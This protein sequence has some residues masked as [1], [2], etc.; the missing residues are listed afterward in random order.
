[1]YSTFNG[2]PYVAGGSGLPSEMSRLL[3]TKNA[4]DDVDEDWPEVSWERI[5]ERDPDVIVVGD[6]SERG[7]A[8]DSAAEKIAMMREHPV[9]SQL[10]AVRDD[11]IIEVPGIEMDP[12]V[13]SAG[14]LDLFADGL[15]DLGHVR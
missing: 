10:A 7:A 4:F 11:K 5:A 13:R 9:V 12:S 15:R 8:G 6:L 14:A 3:G 1:L 2:V